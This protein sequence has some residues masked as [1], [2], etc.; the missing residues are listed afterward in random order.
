MEDCS[1]LIGFDGYQLK[2]LYGGVLLSAM[3]WM[4]TIAST[5]WPLQLLRLSQQKVG[6]FSS[7][8]CP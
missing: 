7:S 2:G 4:G 5:L 8:T 1:T 3:A 6:D